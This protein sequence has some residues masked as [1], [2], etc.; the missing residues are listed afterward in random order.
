M[1]PAHSTASARPNILVVDADEDT[2]SLYQDTL[3]LAG[4]DVC[5]ASDGRDALTKAL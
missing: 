1:M 2:R 3:R 4:C 5:E